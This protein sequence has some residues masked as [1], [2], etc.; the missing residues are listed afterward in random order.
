MTRLLAIETSSEACSLAL[1]VDGRVHESHEHAPLRHA[2]PLRVAA[3]TAVSAAG[4]DLLGVLGG[5]LL[6]TVTTTTGDV[7]LWITDGTGD[8]FFGD[9]PGGTYPIRADIGGS[10]DFLRISGG[11]LHFTVQVAANAYQVWTTD[12]TAAGT[13]QKGSSRRVSKKSR[14]ATRGKFSPSMRSRV[15]RFRAVR[16]AA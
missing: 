6:F 15:A 8:L 9:V 10:A 7:Q 2:E 13:V 5:R 4:A 14:R 3:L 11:L 1:S 12:G 16:W